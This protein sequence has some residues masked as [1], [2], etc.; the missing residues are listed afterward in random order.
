MK[1]YRQKGW[2]LR[3]ARKLGGRALEIPEDVTVDACGRATREVPDKPGHHRIEEVPL[4]Q[5][6]IC[7]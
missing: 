3:R 1:T 2:A 7:P 4:E 6:E 5:L